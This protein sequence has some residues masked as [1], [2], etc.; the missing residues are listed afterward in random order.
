MCKNKCF[1][2]VPVS[3]TKKLRP[4]QAKIKI[5]LC[6]KRSQLFCHRNRVAKKIFNLAHL[7]YIIK[8]FTIKY[9]EQFIL[10]RSNNYTFKKQNK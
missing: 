6:F 7:Y 4:L 8:L 10:V 2:C 9:I 5:Y 1:I 3:V